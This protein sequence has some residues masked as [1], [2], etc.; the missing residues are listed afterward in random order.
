MLLDRIYWL[1]YNYQIFG[2][3]VEVRLANEQIRADVIEKYKLN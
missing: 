2:S 1:K 3:Q